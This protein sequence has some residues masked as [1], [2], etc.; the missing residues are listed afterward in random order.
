[1]QLA[2]RALAGVG[3]SNGDRGEVRRGVPSRS[4]APGE[5]VAALNV[6]AGCAAGRAALLGVWSGGRSGGGGFCRRRLQAI[7]WPIK[8]LFCR[9]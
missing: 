5:R 3:F 2:G 6:P 7:Y 8:E 4:P 9:I 1:M